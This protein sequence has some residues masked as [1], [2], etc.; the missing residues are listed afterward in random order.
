[1]TR[2][3]LGAALAGAA[4]LATGLAARWVAPA[5]LGGGMLV[6]VAFSLATVMRRPRLEMEREVEPSSVEK[7]RPAVALIHVKNLGRRRIRAAPMEQWFGDR[8]IRAE[9]PTLR[10]GETAVRTYPLPTTR[11]GTFELGPVE[12]PRA[13]PFGLCRTA[14]RMGDPQ[15]VSVRPRVLSVRALPTGASRNLEGP[16]S[17][18][19]PQGSVVFHRLREYVVGD[20]LRTVHWPSTAHMGRLVVR[21]N[22]DTAQPYSVVLLDLDR[23]R[24]SSDAFEQA[25]D[26]T[27]SVAVSLS[28]RR[29]PVLVRTSAGDRIGGP[30][31]QD[32]AG[33]VG[34]LTDVQPADGAGLD[35]Q[36][37]QLRR[38]R[39]GT[40][41]VVVTGRVDPRTV[42]T[43]A[44][45]R[46]RFERAVLISVGDHPAPLPTHPALATI[47]AVSAEDAVRRWNQVMAR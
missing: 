29:A 7:G 25:V 40:A 38:D 24:Y 3:G 41:V 13:D 22:V 42:P 1:M 44:S 23:E 16:S 17:D 6:L 45:L 11:R 32:P 34:F 39:G 43:V 5:V 31:Y 2:F 27:A 33:I 20:D 15:R 36:V 14:Q 26:V 4:L 10:P 47:Q 21:H 37:I 8:C 12:V 18:A 30:T 35:A 46:R 19:A 28:V 9:L